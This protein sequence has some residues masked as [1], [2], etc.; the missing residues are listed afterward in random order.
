MAVCG[1]FNIRVKFFAVVLVVQ[2]VL[3]GQI[4]FLLL[5]N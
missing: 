2:H 3:T 4:S 1:L 5:L